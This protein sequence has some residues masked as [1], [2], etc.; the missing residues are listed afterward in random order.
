MLRN[1]QE[2]AV[3]AICQHFESGSEEHAVCVLPTGAGKS[4]VIAYA[5]E[6]VGGNFLVFQPTK[7]ILL[8]NVEKY[9]AL[10]FKAAV[11]CD[12]VKRKEVGPVT[13]AT[14]GSVMGNRK[15]FAKFKNVLIDECHLVNG[16]KG[17]YEYFLRMQGATVVGLTATPYRLKSS[18]KVSV[19]EFLTRATQPF[20]KKVIHVTQQQELRE[21]GF[22]API[23]YKRMHEINTKNVLVRNGEYEETTLLKEMERVSIEDVIIQEIEILEKSEGSILVFVEFVEILKKIQ[24]KR[25]DLPYVT[26]ATHPDERREL[27]KKFK[28]GEVKTVLNV[29]VLTTGF[30]H[31]ALSRIIVAKATR[32]LSLWYQIVGRGQRIADGKDGCLV[33]DMCDNLS[34][35]GD[36]QKLVVVQERGKWIV[37]MG[38]KTITNRAIIH[39]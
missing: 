37:K 36:V 6:R 29:G 38:W 10:G 23:V 9:E 1:Y 15:L 20:F 12:A 30:D 27:L 16:E 28:K 11:Y 8:Q 35:L 2:V 25:P 26:G 18:G 24:K 7:E 3:G 22:L 32:S 21:A 4:W 31:P 39:E 19:I 5:V 34:V 17:Q 33:V 14:I 13:F